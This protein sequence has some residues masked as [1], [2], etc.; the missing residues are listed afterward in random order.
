MLAR[1][2]R[3]EEDLST[4]RLLVANLAELSGGPGWVETTTVAMMDISKRVQCMHE[5]VTANHKLF[6]N[7]KRTE[8]MW[9]GGRVLGK[10]H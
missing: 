7:I 10:L 5:I 3:I 2:D 8:D 6:E 4:L 1:L 9:R